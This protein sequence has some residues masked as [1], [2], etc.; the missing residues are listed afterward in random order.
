[1]DFQFSNSEYES[2][3]VNTED[4]RKSCTLCGMTFSTLSNA[5]RHFRNQHTNTERI[6]CNLCQRTFKNSHSHNEH[7]RINHGITQSMLKAQPLIA[8][9]TSWIYELSV[10]IIFGVFFYIKSLLNNHLYIYITTVFETTVTYS[11]IIKGIF[12]S[13]T[14]EYVSL[15]HLFPSQHFLYTNFY[16]MKE[17]FS[18]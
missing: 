6:P 10:F 16:S 18:L 2:S 11:E 8:E 15:V 4:G 9:T 12:P 1:M 13:E 7:L 14:H 5:Q 3:V 17:I